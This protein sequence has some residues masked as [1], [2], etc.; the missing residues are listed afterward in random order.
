VR[1]IDA[2]LWCTGFKYDFPF[3]EGSRV[4]E[5]TSGKCPTAAAVVVVVVV[6]AVIVVVVVVVVVVAVV[7][8]T[9]AVLRPCNTH[10]GQVT[11]T[12][13]ITLRLYTTLTL[14]LTLQQQ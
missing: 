6:A 4:P 11:L 3:L 10:L 1:D 14:T 8:V 13:Y 9:A 12:L 5:P 7:A 2:V